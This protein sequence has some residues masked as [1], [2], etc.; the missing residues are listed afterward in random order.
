MEG[1]KRKKGNIKLS[2]ARISTSRRS[3]AL[4]AKSVIFLIHIAL[5]LSTFEARNGNST[6]A[7]PTEFASCFR[8]LSRINCSLS[9]LLRSVFLI[10]YTRAIFHAG[11]SGTTFSRTGLAIKMCYRRAIPNPFSLAREQE[12]AE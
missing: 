6:R 11:A 8:L 2:F 4:A 9:P 12:R 5:V 7:V 10:D 1:K 3:A